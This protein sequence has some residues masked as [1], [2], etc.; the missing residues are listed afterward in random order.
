MNTKKG[1][2][3]VD[4]PKTN[5]E[6]EDK[7]AQLLS[8]WHYHIQ[9]REKYAHKIAKNER[10]WASHAERVAIVFMKMEELEI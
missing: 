4:I 2:R 5:S 3:I 9:K 8:Q 10:L 7:K 6:I 1:Q